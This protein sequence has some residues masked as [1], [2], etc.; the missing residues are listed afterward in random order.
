M[1]LSSFVTIYT[2][3]P[4]PPFTF[5]ALLLLVENSAI[6]SVVLTHGQPDSTKMLVFVFRIA[7]CAWDGFSLRRACA[8]VKSCLS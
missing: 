8:T 1:T 2:G 7:V 6:I 4:V 3:H 5:T